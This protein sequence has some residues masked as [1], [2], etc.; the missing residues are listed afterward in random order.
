MDK[1]YTDDLKLNVKEVF[2]S[3]KNKKGNITL[4]HPIEIMK[5]YNLNYND[6]DKIIEYLKNLGLYGIEVKHSKQT[7][8]N[9]KEFLKIAKKYNLFES[10]G[11]DY[12]GEK[13]K[14]DVKIG[15]CIKK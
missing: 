12:H 14:P 3:I 9:Q 13:I 10:C 1:L 8:E 7:K 15:E 5:E 11:S 4:A 6:I 2:N